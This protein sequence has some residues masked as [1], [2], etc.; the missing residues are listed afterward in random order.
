MPSRTSSA[1]ATLRRQARGGIAAAFAMATDFLLPPVCVACQHPLSGHD[2]LCAACWRRIDFIRAPLCDRLGCPLPF[3]TGVKTV[4]AAALADP[5]LYD[6]ARAAAHFDGPV[7]DLVHALKYGDRHDGRRLLGRWLSAAGADLLHDADVIMPVPLHRWRLFSRRFNQAAILA[8]ELARQRGIDWDA[9]ALIRVRS[10]PQQVGMTRDQRQHNV[11]A[12]FQVRDGATARI[13]GRRI[14]LVDDVI[15][16]GATGD[17]CA[18]AL[19]AAGATRIDVLA[20][21]MVVDG[22]V[23]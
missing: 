3:D 4:S 18:H 10:T 22:P 11:R 8:Q 14:V 9:D 15:T 6:R 7:R 12:A 5:P 21:A 17:A 23:R 13:D 16:T 2:T 19:R 20:V 1:F